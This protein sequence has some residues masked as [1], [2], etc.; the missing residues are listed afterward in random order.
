MILNLQ[1]EKIINYIYKKQKQK[2]VHKVKAPKT[3]TKTFVDDGDDEIY[4][5]RMENYR[6]E[7]LKK[8]ELEDSSDADTSNTQLPLPLI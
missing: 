5:E 2:N 3:K 1:L 8:R 6:Q 4:Y 7:L